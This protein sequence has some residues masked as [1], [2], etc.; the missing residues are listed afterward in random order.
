MLSH[1]ERVDQTRHLVERAHPAQMIPIAGDGR[2]AGR[3]R[4]LLHDQAAFDAHFEA[5]QLLRFDA[6]G[7][8]SELT[9]RD[10][11]G[12]LARLELVPA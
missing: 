10:V 3:A 4:F 2:A 11:Q 7:Q 9:Q 6:L 12:F 8:A 5:L 1:V